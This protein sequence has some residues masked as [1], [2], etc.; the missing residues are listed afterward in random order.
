MAGVPA[1]YIEWSESDDD[2]IV[3]GD[4]GY[5]RDD[6]PK[7]LEPPAPV[8]PEVR[9]PEKDDEIPTVPRTPAEL[10]ED[11]RVA[12]SRGNV[13]LARDL[14]SRGLDVNMECRS[15]WSALV[16][17][18]FSG[19]PEMV[20]LLVDHGADVNASIGVTTPLMAACGT[21]K[22]SE[23]ALVACA[24][25]LLKH[26]AEPDLAGRDGTT[27]L[28]LAARE[29]HCQLIE[30][31]LDRGADAKRLDGQGWT[32]L[33]WAA[34]AGQG[35]AARFLLMKVPFDLVSLVTLDGQ[36]PSDLASSQGYHKLSQVL[37]K[38]EMEFREKQGQGDAPSLEAEGPWNASQASRKYQEAYGDVAL[39]LAAIGAEERLPLF[40]EHGVCFRE[41]LNLDEEALCKMGI[42]SKE[43]RAKIIAGVESTR[44]FQIVATSPGVNVD[45]ALESVLSAVD[46]VELA[47]TLR[48]HGVS[49]LE[50]LLKL[51]EEGLERAGVTQVGSRS[52]LAAA[53]RRAHQLPWHKSSI[54][55]HRK[56]ATISCP[57]AVS[58]VTTL[59]QHLGH[60]EVSVSHLGNHL[61]KKPEDLQLGRDFCSTR[62]LRK[63]LRE[64][65]EALRLLSTQMQRLDQLA[66]KV[67]GCVEYEPQWPPLPVEVKRSKRLAWVPLCLLFPALWA[68][69]MAVGQLSHWPRLLGWFLHRNM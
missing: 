43:E 28:M 53:I 37:S 24:E 48:E 36:M 66:A 68:C 39:V 58:V 67:E 60:L 8:A 38:F 50:T 10:Q 47:D 29:G 27:P 62:H 46:M 6:M 14:I 12:V 41:M 54:P 64:A 7:F 42:E 1:D 22:G 59:R 13:E 31:L 51:D 5:G 32:S 35:R 33:S 4:D 26:G 34:Y 49:T 19:Y 63:E 20:Q 9:K 3:F 18:C 23:A 57:E 30:L 11:F 65:H 69:K 61:S 40:V 15:N 45:F 55:D 44:R 16:Q 56:S 17:A 25:I 52:R 21:W 2:E